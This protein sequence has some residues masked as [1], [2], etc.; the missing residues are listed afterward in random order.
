MK[1]ISAVS[2]F[3]L[4]AGLSCQKASNT[5]PA[6]NG[7]DNQAVGASAH[8]L[9]SAANYTS[10]NLEI[11]YMP[12]FQPDA[13][14]VGNLTS[15]L[16]MLVNKPGGIQVTQAQIPAAGSATLSQADVENI[17]KQYRTRSTGGSRLAIYILFT[18]GNYTANGVLGFAYLNTSICIFGK[19]IRD[20]SGGVGQIDAATL[21]STVLEHEIGHIMG[22]V[23]LGSSMQ[24]PHEDSNHPHHC[25]NQNCL[26]YYATETTDALAFLTG[27]NVPALDANCR[28]DLKANGG[29]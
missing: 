29:K 28:A 7:Y 3:I 11:Q 24:T 4:L 22:L 14:A 21:E 25:N 27:G 5:V 10:V 13:G 16:N 26:M 12:G 23:N 17:E 18:N 9:L 1:I 6:D 2:L 8:D 20:N 19:T 15:F